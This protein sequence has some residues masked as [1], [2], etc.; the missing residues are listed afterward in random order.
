MIAAYEF[1]PHH[2]LPTSL[3][4]ELSTMLR[5][6]ANARLQTARLASSERVQLTVHCPTVLTP[7]LR[8]RLA[9]AVR[10][11]LGQQVTLEIDT[12]LITVDAPA[13]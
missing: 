3:E 2:A 1:V 6:D 13:P 7:Q 10:T 9:Q 5:E 4:A 12:R 8:S 11:Q